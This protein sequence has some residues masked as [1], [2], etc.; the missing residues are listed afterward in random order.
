MIR[1]KLDFGCIV[2]GSACKSYTKRLEPIH[3][4]GVRLSLGDFRTSPMQSLYIEANDPPLYLR[5]IK[6]SLQY[7][8][9]LMSNE[10]NPA[11]PVVFHPQNNLKLLFIYENKEKAIKPL[12]LRVEKHL[13]EVGFH[14]HMVAPCRLSST[15]PWK[16]VLICVSTRSVRLIP[17]TLGCS[18]LN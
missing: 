13:D 4:Q 18:L 17:F 2:Y 5:R 11:Y 10:R 7:G 14:P 15:P 9:Q 3:N 1:S 12:G 16:F 8:S 6:L